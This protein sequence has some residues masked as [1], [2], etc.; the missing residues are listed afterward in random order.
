[1]TRREQKE[2]NAYQI[3]PHEFVRA[4]AANKYALAPVGAKVQAPHTTLLPL[5][6]EQISWRLTN[7]RRPARK[8]HI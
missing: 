5:A 4:T 6:V 3:T 2:I 1:M 8:T 7:P